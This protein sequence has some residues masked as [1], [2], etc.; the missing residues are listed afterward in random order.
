VV[1][2]Q[3]RSAGGH[4]LAARFFRPAGAPRAAVLV[5]GAMGVQQDY[6]ADFAR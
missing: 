3:L 1:E 5:A 4:P 6:Y 2:Q